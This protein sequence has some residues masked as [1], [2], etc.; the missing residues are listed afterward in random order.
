MPRIQ[1]IFS[2]EGERDTSQY[3]NISYQSLV[4]SF[5]GGTIQTHI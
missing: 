3:H 2:S 1:L 5:D 4:L